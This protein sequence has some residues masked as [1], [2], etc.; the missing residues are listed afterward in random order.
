MRFGKTSPWILLFA[1][2]CGSGVP[3]SGG[4]DESAAA[5]GASPAND[6]SGAA[7]ALIAGP[8]PVPGGASLVLSMPVQFDGYGV[9]YP[10]GL[11]AVQ[12]LY[13]PEGTFKEYGALQNIYGYYSGWT[14]GPSG[15]QTPTGVDTSLQSQLIAYANGTQ[16]TTTPDSNDHVLDRVP[17]GGEIT[18]GSPYPASFEE[19]DGRGVG[20]A[21]EGQ[22]FSQF[23]FDDNW[24]ARY[25]SVAYGAPQPFGLWATT[26]FNRWQILGLDASNWTPYGSASPDDLALD[27]LYSLATGNVSGAVSTWN[28]LLSI[29]GTAYD[30]GNQR[31]T[32]P[33]L[34]A[35]YYL[36]LFKILTDRILQAGVDAATT[37]TLI[38]HSVAL[39][40]NILSDQ[41]QENGAPIGWVT[42][43]NTTDRND[44]SSLINT[45]TT[46]ADVLGLG[47]GAH[48]SFEVG[49]A[50]LSTPAPSSA[51][52]F[53]LR[54]HNVLSAVVGLSPT[55]MMSYGPYMNLPAGSHTVDFYLR[56]PNPTG[57]VAYV[58]I[59]DATANTVLASQ[60]VMGSELTTG[61]AWTRI[62]VP[63]TVAS[64]SDALEFRIAWR[65]STNLDAATIRVR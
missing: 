54:P 64:A 43:N 12:Y 57:D 36:G 39:R 52:K 40:S 47:A 46:V 7:N 24:F 42:G 51:G 18:F 45:E 44:P 35:E 25:V 16:A 17:A 22:P 32:Y 8:Q 2:G 48:L 23:W 14:G 55:G 28:T 61:N 5:I 65:G 29:A 33:G 19:H 50:P 9:H 30:A 53:F 56:A 38:Q 3:D 15:N 4:T 63:V 13:G 59:N 31:Y 10:E 26:D 11:A 34:T 1:F 37:S 62:S 6:S 41:Q 21:A 20:G 27:G 49:R 58:D 60:E